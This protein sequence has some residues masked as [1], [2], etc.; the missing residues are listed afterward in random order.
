MKKHKLV[1][2]YSRVRNTWCVFIEKTQVTMKFLWKCRN[3]EDAE[4]LA[5][6]VNKGARIC[7]GDKKFN[8]NCGTC[9]K[10]KLIIE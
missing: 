4:R 1:A 5:S 10:C 9:L 8:S 3:E 7:R 6:E 2:C